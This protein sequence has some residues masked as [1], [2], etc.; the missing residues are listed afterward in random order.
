MARSHCSP[1]PENLCWCS[2]SSPCLSTLA[3]RTFRL[4]VASSSSPDFGVFIVDRPPVA[5]PLQP[6][7]FQSSLVG[8]QVSGRGSGSAGHA[9]DPIPCSIAVDGPSVRPS[10]T[11]CSFVAWVENEELFGLHTRRSDV[12]AAA[13]VFNIEIHRRCDR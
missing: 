4:Q 7:N 5:N 11:A 1:P 3:C 2:S 13:R 8:I 10:Y 6:S 9:V 12:V